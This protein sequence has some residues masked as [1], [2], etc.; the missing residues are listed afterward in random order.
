MVAYKRAHV[1]IL[2]PESLLS[3]KLTVACILRIILEVAIAPKTILA[4][5]VVEQ[6]D[7]IVP[8]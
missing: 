5:Q 2:K 7:S 3:N 6:F 4:H 1:V 8:F